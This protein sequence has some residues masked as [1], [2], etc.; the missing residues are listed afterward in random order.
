MKFD[1]D[2]IMCFRGVIKEVFQTNINPLL[3]DDCTMFSREIQ[4]GIRYRSESDIYEVFRLKEN[5]NPDSKIRFINCE[6]ITCS[7][8][9]NFSDSVKE[10]CL[11]HIKSL[12]C[13]RLKEVPK[14]KYLD[15]E[16]IMTGLR[17][18]RDEFSIDEMLCLHG[19]DKDGSI[20]F[21]CSN[22]YL[23]IRHYPN[24]R[25]FNLSKAE[26]IDPEESGDRSK[27]GLAL[28]GCLG[29]TTT[30]K[31]FRDT[32]LELMFRIV[33]WHVFNQFL[34]YQYS[35]HFGHWLKKDK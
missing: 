27:W 24:K 21:Y 26:L 23:L 20:Y 8:F 33:Q 17:F 15:L 35:T 34:Y 10:V 22:S 11:S 7:E 32:L 28:I 18:L 1:S 19:K 6:Q 30:F 25:I 3:L 9:D 29:P 5:I 16:W 12:I 13:E 2:H 4:H 14:L 31:N